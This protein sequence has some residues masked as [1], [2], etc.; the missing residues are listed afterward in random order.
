MS[1]F[2]LSDIS[3]KKV[4]VMFKIF[5]MFGGVIVFGRVQHE[6]YFLFFKGFIN[7]FVRDV[8][9]H[10]GWPYAQTAAVS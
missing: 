6:R 1:Y 10:V 4:I 8:N 3:L 9:R 7:I 2:S 5:I